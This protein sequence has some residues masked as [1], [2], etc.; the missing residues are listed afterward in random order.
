MKVIN[1]NQKTKPLNEDELS[2]FFNEFN[3]IVESVGT[4]RSATET[5]ATYTINDLEFIYYTKGGSI[6]TIQGKDYHCLMNDLMILQPHGIY[7]S[8]NYGQKEFEYIYIHFQ[9]E[10]ITLQTQLLG[11]FAQITPV[12]HDKDKELLHL[13]LI[14]LKEAESNKPGANAL[15]NMLIKTICIDIIRKQRT[16]QQR[17]TLR[18]KHKDQ[19]EL[20]NNI[21]SYINLHIRDNLN[22][23]QL[24]IQFNISPN[25][26]YKSFIN[27]M[28][29]SPSQFIIEYRIALAKN[30]LNTN[31]YNLM[32]I[33]ELCGFSCQQHFT[34]SFT[35]NV[36]VSPNNYRKQIIS[37]KKCR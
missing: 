29:K 11:L 19:I 28:E 17:Y 14:I 21:I 25:Y 31:V 4:W 9:V 6:T 37:N 36:G 1:S 35:Q 32:Q 26:L 7:T 8:L 5:Q 24:A 13:F 30:Y 10:P 27:V 33:S 2:R 12:I 15:I 3:I 22:I 16:F 34:R 18:P 20:I 23:Q